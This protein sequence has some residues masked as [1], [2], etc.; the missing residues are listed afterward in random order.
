MYLDKYEIA[1]ECYKELGTTGAT[2]VEWLFD[3][4]GFMYEQKGKGDKYYFFSHEGE[5]MGK[6]SR[7]NVDLVF[8]WIRIK[9]NVRPTAITSINTTGFTY[10]F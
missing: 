10:A 1:Y 4:V 7:V 5:E 3:G 8:R 6:A 9:F 2:I